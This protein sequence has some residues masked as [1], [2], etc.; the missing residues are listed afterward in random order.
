MENISYGVLKNKVVSSIRNNVELAL[1][2]IY[3]SGK[4]PLYIKLLDTE[5]GDMCPFIKAYN[6]DMCENI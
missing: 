4:G 5:N 2:N 6:N 1:N 3:T